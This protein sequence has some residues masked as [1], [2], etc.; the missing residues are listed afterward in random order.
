MQSNAREIVERITSFQK[1][2]GEAPDFIRPLFREGLTREER[3]AAGL[4]GGIKKLEMIVKGQANSL[5]RT[6]GK[7][8][9]RTNAVFKSLGKPILKG[10]N[11]FGIALGRIAG[12]V[13]FART[14]GAIG[15]IIARIGPKLF[16]GFGGDTGGL[17]K[18]LSKI[19]ESTALVVE[20]IGAFLTGDKKTDSAIGKAFDTTSILKVLATVWFDL[21]KGV[22]NF[23]LEQLD[24][25]F[26]FGKKKLEEIRANPFKFFED[27]LDSILQ[28]IF[29]GVGAKN[30]IGE[31]RKE[32]IALV[33]DLKGISNESVANLIPGAVKGAFKSVTNALVGKETR[34]FLIG[35]EVPRIPRESAAHDEAVDTLIFKSIKDGFAKAGEFF[36]GKDVTKSINERA[37]QLQKRPTIVPHPLRNKGD[38]RDGDKRARPKRA[39]DPA[40]KKTSAPLGPQTTNKATI[41]NYFA[42][43]TNQPVPFMKRQISTQFGR[44]VNNHRIG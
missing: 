39:D 18:F 36:G 22:A 5:E 4:K 9:G 3:L 43:T 40:I 23:W 37:A 34:E 44:I 29:G 31:I 42:I 28:N 35:P 32:R 11:T 8:A 6:L 15:R 12:T 7:M 13:S 10:I 26:K 2:G 27:K 16:R 25:L 33:A 41:N 30:F 14:G 1:T 17:D 38:D 24:K 21:F 19:I 20:D